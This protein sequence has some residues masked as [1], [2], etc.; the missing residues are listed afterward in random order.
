MKQLA[1]EIQQ[2]E[3]DCGTE[4]LCVFTMNVRA[5][6]LF[7]FPCGYKLILVFIIHTHNVVV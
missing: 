4:D 6:T 1:T 3:G 7:T 5:A 2:V